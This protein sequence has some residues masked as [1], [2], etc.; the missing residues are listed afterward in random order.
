MLSRSLLPRIGGKAMISKEAAIC[1][2][3]DLLVEL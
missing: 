3:I 1:T 2:F